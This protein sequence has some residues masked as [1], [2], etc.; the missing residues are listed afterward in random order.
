[1]VH[2]P[3]K[4]CII[5]VDDLNMP[6]K[7]TYG[8]QPPIELLRQYLDHRGWYDVKKLEYRILED[9]IILAVMGPPGGGRT[10][11]TNR[12]VRHFNMLT[13]T[14][15]D[16]ATIEYIFG[17]IVEFFLKRF[18]D[19]I[20]NI[21][22]SLVESVLHVYN[23]VK[24]ELRPTPAKSFYT[25]NL[26]DIS[27]VF[28]GICSANSKNYT[29]PA[30]IVRLWYHENL[31]VFHDR[32]TTEEDRAFLKDILKSQ[33]DKFK[34]K[35]EDVL[36][37]ERIIFG[38]FM[39]GR[40]VEQK[41]YVQIQ[42]LNSLLNRMENYLEDY[43]ADGGG[44]SKKQ[45]KLVMFLDAC[46]HIA[47]ICRILR[48]PQG[49]ALLLG[50]GGSGRQSLARLASFISN[51]RLFQIEVVKGYNMG[52]WRDDLKRCLMIAGVEN[53]PVSF[54]FVD[55]QIINEQMLEDI[56][57]ILNTGDV[58]NL[59]RN[60][61]FDTIYNAC[62]N[63]CVKKGIQPNKMNMFAQYLSRVQRNIHC[64]IAMSPLGE[65]FRTRLR[66]FPSLINCST[67]DW[68]TEWPEEA[69]IGVGRG[70]LEEVAQDLGI[71]ELSER[72]VEMFK[73][74]HKSVEKIS[75][76]FVQELRRY[77]YVTPTSYLEQ[78]NLFKSILSVKRIDLK[79][80]IDRL[81]NGLEKLKE[82]NEAVQVLEVAL[83]EMKPQIEQAEI[84]TTKMME[85]LA[86]DK[87]EADETQK[88][89]AADEAVATKQQEEALTLQAEALTAVS[90]AQ[91]MLDKTM[92]DVKSLE[93]KHLDEIKAFNNPPAA[94]FWTLAGVCVLFGEKVPAK[95]VPG[96]LTG[97]KKEDYFEYAKKELLSRPKEFLSRLFLFADSDQ[98]DNIPPERITKFEAKIKNE[99]NF[100]QDKVNSANQATKYLWGWVNAMYMYYQTFTSTKPLREKLEATQKLLA[101]KTAELAIKRE[102]LKRINAAIKDL[103]DQY[104]ESIRR[105]EELTNKKMECELKLERA[106]KLTSG[107]GDEKDR[108]SREIL[109][110]EKRR[111]LLPG[112]AVV[113]AGM[114]AYAG[115]FTSQFRNELEAGWVKGLAELDIP[116]TENI[117][118]RAFLG[119]SVKIQTWNIA[120]L[121][122]DDT[123]TENGIIIDKSRRWSLM[124]DPQTQA[125]KFIKNLGRD[126][127]EG[128]DVLKTS[129]PNLLRTIELA[130]RFG[131]WVLL[132]NVGTEL[133]P[134]L[135]PIL[136]QQTFK[137]GG[138]LSI[139]IGDKAI[140]YH[141]SFRFYMTTTNPNPHYPPE[142]FVKVTILNF[143]ITPSGL[144]EQMLAQIVALE[145]P[146]L[147]QKKTEIVKKN[148]QDKKELQLLEDGILKSLS[149]SQGDILMDESLIN[150]LASSKKLSTEIN[151]RI[152][153]SKVTEQQIDAKRESYRPVAFRASI[154]FFCI[155]DLAT[156]DP[157]Y[158]YSLQWFIN[159]FTMG[160]EKAPPSNEHDQRLANL[161]NYFTYSLY[162]NIC[163][164]LFEKHKLLFSL[165][166]TVRTLQGDNNMDEEEWRYFLAGFTGELK[167]PANP[168]DW[169]PENSWPGVYRQFYGMESLPKLK[170]IEAHFMENSKQ[171]QAIYDAVE[172]QEQPL[173]EPW[174]S[175]L[176]EFEKMI[177]LK[178]IRPDKLV[179]AVQSWVTLKIG[180][181]FVEPPT[182]NLAECFKDATI[183]TP[184]IFVLS[185]GSDPVADFLRF[186]EEMGF[187]KRYDQISLGQG[188]GPK[189]ERMIREYSQKGGW[190]LLQ[191]CHLAT[192][193]M[194]ELEKLCEELNDSMHREFRLWLTSMPT[195]SFP[196]SVL[197]N[198]IKM[199]LEPPTGLRANLMRT[200]NTI[201][202]KDLN[203][204]KKPEAYKK[205]LFGFAL[206]HAI[207]LERRKF[208]PIGW[209]IPYEFTNEDFT[210]CKRQL[211][212]F[213]D[214]YNEIPYKVLNYIG[215][216]I[217]YG[218]RVT[219][220]KDVRLIST[221][222]RTYMTP[223]TLRDG[224][225]FSESGIYYSP[226]AADQ[227]DYLTYIKDL[228]LNPSPEVFGLH[229]N[230]EI[231]TAEN[232]TR[233][234]LQNILS[235]QP[236]AASKSGKSPEEIIIE[237]ATS[238]EKN[239][240]PVFDFDAI[241][242]KYPTEYTESM[243]TV[244]VQEVIRYNRILEIM[245][246]SLANL[247]KAV[248]GEIVMSE[249]L[250]LMSRS[251]AENQVPELWKARSFLSLKPLASW[252]EDLNQR[253]DF[254]TNW[255]NNGTPNYFW[256]AGFFFPQ[257]FVTGM[258]QN[259]ARKHVIA[260]DRVGFESHILDDKTYLDIKEKPEDGCYI[261]GIY[262]EG[263]R[264]DNK[265]HLLGPSRPKELYT[266]VPLMWLNPVADRKPPKEGIY[267]CPIYKVVSRA[268]TLSTTGHSTNFVMF[269]ELPT[270]QEED[271]WIKAGVAAFLSLRY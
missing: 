188:Q 192:S 115:P 136:N 10:F 243:N 212:I 261:Y 267:N 205:L 174:N 143:A 74:V 36:N 41:V 200:Y 130:I 37:A 81:K 207:L 235:T 57:N 91:K 155:N 209:N 150:K 83:K 140:P 79:G 165:L 88:Q 29:E 100:Q 65:V 51:Y 264:W 148:A 213:L 234:L 149:E 236:R 47:R 226:P 154:L 145:D 32:L 86:V 80:Q 118:M 269:M 7:E 9:L 8:A 40:E 133:D 161:N 203:D 220:D 85:K 210:V 38:D 162:E 177:V 152:K 110:F 21:Q 3:A 164:S 182:F 54:L 256:I 33:F 17:T 265:K 132:E 14:E 123:S 135:E 53:K 233:T 170:G 184:L 190:V 218:G 62:R 191:N 99:P 95:P 39:Q 183:T 224:H 181:Q 72:L 120:G 252:I 214:E 13:Y 70:S 67:I 197:Q 211:K 134:A 127:P 101:E 113:S 131:K 48:Q 217:N 66:M 156:I 93:Q 169:I 249:E 147:E 171:Y 50:I 266:D 216:E 24:A 49:N 139:M 98:K 167:I 23:T 160:V 262:L 204:C 82:A 158:Q 61:D 222:L 195:P 125:N 2:Q 122:K 107:L 111:V 173:P 129:D 35:S 248:K 241:Y 1:M 30:Q 142:T 151:Q 60:E 208:G 176:D 18:N 223:G 250:E 187:S 240:P 20:K 96:S 31:R 108:W 175:Q 25:F 119:D 87:K 109:G 78:L 263:A 260:I 159:L 237:L 253:I 206:F 242:K 68:F 5:F 219:D 244:L 26:R 193:W 71:T 44:S 12:L 172:A 271:V 251:L 196:I 257:A 166:L 227:L 185:A 45:M 199:T 103:E 163:R 230:A 194:P 138:T 258:L 19:S 117:N 268:G 34:T 238:L 114:V 198:G 231:I 128:L 121:P 247:K 97:E 92:E 22:K 179:P 11:I 245:P 94:V 73:T 58:T 28:Q 84:D 75:I 42:D 270:K 77:N 201:D 232:I 225:H 146:Q 6:K 4:K 104:E 255:I 55:T 43:N 157:M 178:A 116:H 64:I 239:V 202:D 141:E 228:P 246:S 89:V 76:K 105:K 137:Q 15:L 144:E 126:H 56:N 16:E 229:D 112:D 153:D 102:E 52:K 186:A 69:L 59:Y 254:L 90:E 189:A 180:K 215:A 124:I 63:D 46:E 259:Y 168:T 106:N 221:I 27:K